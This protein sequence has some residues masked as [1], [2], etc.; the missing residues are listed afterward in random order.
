MKDNT[1][2]EDLKQKLKKSLGGRVP[3]LTV[4]KGFALLS[5][6]FAT[7]CL[8]AVMTS[9]QQNID[10]KEISVTNHNAGRF[11]Q[12][13]LNFSNSLVPIQ[14]NV[15]IGMKATDFDYHKFVE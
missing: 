15:Q 9:E 11:L 7:V 8:V 4:K 3:K 6:L 13:K 10:V 5:L 1:H 12:E 14:Q 2:Y